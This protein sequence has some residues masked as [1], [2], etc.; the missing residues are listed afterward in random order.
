MKRLLCLAAFTAAL[1]LPLHP[2]QAHA[3]S[4]DD[5]KALISSLRT[6]TAAVVF[7]DSKQG[8]KQQEQLLHHLDKASRSLDLKSNDLAIAQM[9]E[10]LLNIDGDVAS[11][12][13]TADTA[14]PLIAGANDIIACIGSIQ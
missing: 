1:V 14:A 10:Y 7:P 4:V 5:C 11:G 6:A 8:N 13:I 3:S 2:A 12:K 9:N